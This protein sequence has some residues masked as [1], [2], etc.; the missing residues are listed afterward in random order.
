MLAMA[1][2]AAAEGAEETRQLPMSPALF[3]ITAIVVFAS[4]LAITWAFRSIGNRH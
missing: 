1:L 3:G 2:A 4:L